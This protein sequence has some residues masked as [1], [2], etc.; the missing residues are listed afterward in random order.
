MCLNHHT[1]ITPGGAT[2][3]RT[4]TIY[5]Q[6]LRTR[7]CR[8]HKTARA[9]TETVHTPSIYLSYKTILGCR[10]I[11]SSAIPV[12]I[13]YLVDKLRRMLQSNTDG[14]TLS[15]DFNLR[16]SQIA[17][18]IPGTMTCCKNHRSTIILLSTCCQVN[19]F[20]PNH[21]VTFQNKTSHLGLKMHLTATIDNSIAHILYH[22]RQL[23]CTN[24]RMG[25]CK[26]VRIGT[27]L[28]ENIQNLIHAAPL[29]ASGIKLTVTIRSGS[30]F[31]KTIV[32]LTIHL[33]GLGDVGKVLFTL[34]H[35]LA[36]LQ[37]NRAIS[38]LYQTQGSKE[39]ARSLSYH[40]DS[41]TRT[42]IRIFCMDILIILRHLIDIGTYLQIHKNGTLA[43]INTAF[44]Y[45]HLIQGSYIQPFFLSQITLDAFL[46]GSLFWQNSNLIFLNHLL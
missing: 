2:V 12:V 35:V 23:I 4:H 45:P 26:D 13:L 6:L 27:M 40:N 15:F 29:L 39:T 16:R 7:S 34:S 21:T 46:I 28:A 42:D 24:M 33:L 18:D 3:A 14:N 8:N 30:T 11:L 25:I 5:H 37:N 38:K 1:G 17:I 31:T 22:A 10:K 32:A 9:H 44:Q 19:S 36:T 20:N 43:G 41:R